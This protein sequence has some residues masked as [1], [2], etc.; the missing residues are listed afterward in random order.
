MKKPVASPP[1]DLQ[2][3]LKRAKPNDP[4]VIEALV[5]EYYGTLYRLAVSVLDDPAEAED[6]VQ[7]AFISAMTHLNEYR[8]EANIKTWMYTITLNTCRGHLRKRRTR[9]TI[10]QALQGLHFVQSPP[11]QPENEA[12]ASET[13]RQLW[14][15]V[16]ALG[17][18]H[19]LPILLRYVHELSAPEI[20]EI[21]NLSEGTVHSRL[22]YAREKLK[23]AVESYAGGEEE[24]RETRG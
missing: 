15:A 13:H 10:Q 18:K 24:L 2:T 6:A 5:S 12:L 7:E 19:R 23:R 1:D 8:A 14:Q 22:H 3:L 20:A 21:L 16:D 4:L 11:P 17:E 9:A